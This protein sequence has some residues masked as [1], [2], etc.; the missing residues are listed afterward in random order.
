MHYLY[1]KA[2]L[3]LCFLD[4]QALPRLH[5][6]SYE[7]RR[8]SAPA[9]VSSC[10][11]TRSGQ[12]DKLTHHAV[13]RTSVAGCNS[14]ANNSSGCNIHILQQRLIDGKGR[15]PYA[16]SCTLPQNLCKVCL[17]ALLCMLRHWNAVNGRLWS[18]LV[19]FSVRSLRFLTAFCLVDSCQ[20][21]AQWSLK[22]KLSNS[23][24]QSMAM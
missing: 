20:Q 23:R 17:D 21:V 2:N 19:R 15:V 24:R 10:S 18:E 4:S 1:R 3:A 8:N 12:H 16:F 22:Y 13:Y 7:E 6:F 11:N 5:A 14:P 9:F